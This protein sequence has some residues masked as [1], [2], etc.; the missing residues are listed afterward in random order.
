M[1][2][3]HKW[4]ENETLKFVSLYKECEILWNV[5][6]TNYKNREKR[7]KAF[8]YIQQ[9]MNMK[10]LTL[11]MIKKKIKAIRDTYHLEKNK[12]TKYKKSGALPDDLSTPRL[13]W[14]N[15][16]ATF[17]EYCAGRECSSSLVWISANLFG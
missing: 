8:E 11:D 9:E 13:V 3:M 6:D 4:S 14:F 10:N 12:I 5:H 1:A 16:A 2:P 17:L 15:E 7:N